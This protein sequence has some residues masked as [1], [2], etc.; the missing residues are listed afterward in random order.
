MFQEFRTQNRT[1]AYTITVLFPIWV[2]VFFIF[3]FI[4]FLYQFIVRCQCFLSELCKDLI[5]KNSIIGSY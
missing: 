4:V 2:C 3:Y 1:H 5:L